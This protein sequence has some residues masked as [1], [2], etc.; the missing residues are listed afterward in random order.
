MM[1]VSLEDFVMKRIVWAVGFLS[2]VSLAQAGGVVC[3]MGGHPRIETPGLVD[4]LNEGEISH[5]RLDDI[6]HLQERLATRIDAVKGV[7]VAYGPEA[8]PKGATIARI[9]ESDM[10]DRLRAVCLVVPP[11]D[12]LFRLATEGYESFEQAPDGTYRSTGKLLPCELCSA[13]QSAAFRPLDAPEG[14]G[15]ELPGARIARSHEANAVLAAWREGLRGI[16][17]AEEWSKLVSFQRDWLHKTV[18]STVAADP[19]AEDACEECLKLK[20]SLCAAV[21]EGIRQAHN[22]KE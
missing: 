22:A 19:R 7:F 8:V 11:Q 14:A 3:A 10:A 13:V 6:R 17:S 2:V 12:E 16:L 15:G 18:A 4:L 5:E 1:G 21:M 20:C 9:V